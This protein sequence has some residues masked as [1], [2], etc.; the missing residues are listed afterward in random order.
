MVFDLVAGIGTSEGRT[1]AGTTEMLFGNSDPEYVYEGEEIKT[2]VTD[3]EEFR[4][5]VRDIYRKCT[6]V[7]THQFDRGVADGMKGFLFSG[8][9]GIGKTELAK[10]IAKE[11]GYKLY[12]VDG[13]E[14]ARA[15]YGESEE[16]LNTVFQSTKNLDSDEHAILLFD[17]IESLIISRDAGLSREWHYSL[18]SI[19]FHE[20]DELDT[21]RAA[22]ICTTNRDDLV[23]AAIRDRFYEITFPLPD[24]EDL[25][26]IA[27]QL[28]SEERFHI[29]DSE[30]VAGILREIDRNDDFDTVR[31]VENLVISRYVDYAAE[32]TES[33]A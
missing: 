3:L 7:I 11:N 6:G 10:F 24:T 9:P 1:T 29:R 16:K 22:V 21:S 17:D 23:D 20:V 33:R 15:K 31:D 18:N 8:P 2:N 25:K 14:V 28:C 5:D 19:F 13:K 27:E 12:F 4:E 30:E 32:E 26:F